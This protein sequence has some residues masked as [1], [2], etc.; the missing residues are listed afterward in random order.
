MIANRLSNT[1]PGE[2]YLVGLCHDLGKLIMALTEGDV[3]GSCLMQASMTGRSLYDIET[4][5]LG[6]DHAL[7][8]AGALREWKLNPELIYVV[9]NHHEEDAVSP[10]GR[11][12]PVLT[13]AQG[14]VGAIGA[15]LES[16]QGIRAAQR[17][18]TGMRRLRVDD[19]FVDSVAA[20]LVSSLDDLQSAVLAMTG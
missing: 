18:Q 5:T 4:E 9:L 3:Y 8:G 20:N 13:L 19:E 16:P 14:V 2:A 12:L 7:V 1:V 10:Q 15:E 11:A 17:R 6:A